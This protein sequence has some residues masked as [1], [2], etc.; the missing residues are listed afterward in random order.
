MLTAPS[1]PWLLWEIE[2][3][4]VIFLEVIMGWN[5]GFER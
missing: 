5:S 2:E 3:I 4:T 1:E